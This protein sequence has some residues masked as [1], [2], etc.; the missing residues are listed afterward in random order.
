MD[1]LKFSFTFQQFSDQNRTIPNLGRTSFL[2]VKL[3]CAIPETTVCACVVAVAS[4]L[5]LEE[6]SNE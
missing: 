3:M 2:H 5:Q 1:F 6:K 4:H